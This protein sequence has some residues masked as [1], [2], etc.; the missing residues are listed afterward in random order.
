[1]K[2]ILLC[3]TV[4]TAIASSALVAHSTTMNGSILDRSPEKVANV[5][6]KPQ[7]LPPRY[8]DGKSEQFND[9]LALK[10]QPLPPRYLDGKSEQFNDTLALKPQPLPPRW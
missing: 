6:L 3:V 9:T 8:L 2:Q 5:A 10:P 4:V 1:M 7:P